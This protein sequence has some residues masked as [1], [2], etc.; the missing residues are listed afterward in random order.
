MEISGTDLASR[1]RAM[2]PATMGAETDVPVWPSVHR[3]LRSV[4]TC[5]QDN[6]PGLEQGVPDICAG[7]TPPAEALAAQGSITNIFIAMSQS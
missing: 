5:V 4:V 1:A 7:L 2:M 6:T 3:C